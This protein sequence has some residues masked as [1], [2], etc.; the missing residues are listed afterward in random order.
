MRNTR[1]L[2][3]F[4]IVAVLAIPIVALADSGPQIKTWVYCTGTAYPTQVYSWDTECDIIW[5]EGRDAYGI[6]TGV[7][8]E[9]VRAGYLPAV[10]QTGGVWSRM[11]LT[12]KVYPFSTSP[13]YNWVTS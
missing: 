5:G 2:L 3:V 8:W 6:S 9:Y 4:S 13:W 11:K 10:V 1:L 7:D 12:T